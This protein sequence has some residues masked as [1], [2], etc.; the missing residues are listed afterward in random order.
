MAGSVAPQVGYLA[1]HPG[2]RQRAFDRHTHQAVQ[3]ADRYYQRSRRNKRHYGFLLKEAHRL[4]LNGGDDF[5]LDF[6]VIFHH[7]RGASSTIVRQVLVVKTLLSALPR[8][9]CNCLFLIEFKFRVFAK[10]REILYSVTR[11]STTSHRL[12][13]ALSTG[14]VHKFVSL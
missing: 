9:K 10:Q 13:T 3:L 7:V 5:N 11:L 6:T 8:S 14:S 1:R 12:H 2:Q 4:I